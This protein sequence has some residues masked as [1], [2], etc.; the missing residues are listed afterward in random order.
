MTKKLFF[1]LMLCLS[2][3]VLF[4]C[5][6]ESAEVE[7][8]NKKK[9]LPRV[10]PRAVVDDIL[11]IAP[12]RWGKWSDNGNCAGYGGTCNWGGGDGCAIMWQGDTEDGLV[13]IEDMEDADAL[14]KIETYQDEGI[15]GFNFIGFS[16]QFLEEYGASDDDGS[17][18]RVGNG[19]KI[20][21]EGAEALGYESI[22]LKKGEY[23]FFINDKTGKKMVYIDAVLK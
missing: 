20:S 4:S 19:I 2:I 12:I 17:T 10:T 16:S 11:F 7:L 14:F 22:A 13:F 9:E 6:K 15:V 21:K 23:S 1:P 18:F 3:F 5:G 8:V